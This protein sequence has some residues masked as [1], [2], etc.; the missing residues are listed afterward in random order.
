MDFNE[1]TSIINDAMFLIDPEGPWGGFLNDIKME[2]NDETKISAFL[3]NGV[4]EG[5]FPGAVLLIA[6][7]GEI[8]FREAMGS[9]SLFSKHDAMKQETIFDL[10]SLTKPLAT[11]LALMKLVESGKIDLDRS[12]KTL[13]PGALPEDKAPITTRLLL[14]HSAGFTDWKPFYLELVNHEPAKRK[15]IL[16]KRIL[17]EPLAY[18][19]GDK[20]LYSDLGFMILEWTIEESSGMTLPRYL[21]RHFYGPL[22]LKKTFFVEGNHQSQ[23]PKQSFASTEDCPWRNKVI[24]GE[25]HDENA[26]ALGGYSGH[27]GLFGTADEVYQIVNLLREHFLG[28]R[29]DY[30]KPQTVRDFF[31]RQDNVKGSSWA[32]GWDTPS[33]EGS[34]AGRYFSRN[35]VG[36]LGFTGTSV[37]MDLEKDVIAILLTNRIHPTRKNEKIR[38]F[39]PKL[40]DLIMEELF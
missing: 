3:E 20:V 37:W 18:L 22:S 5:V 25:V 15:G 2:K 23:I 26:H 24:R 31:T 14:C 16:R 19:P 36:H 10:A 39:R 30:L 29:Q 38:E 17:Q 11:T 35:S 9:C 4:G 12:I 40:H 7:G 33:L 34:S 1:L 32:L 27:A 21:A 8:V 13:L 6:W 28:K